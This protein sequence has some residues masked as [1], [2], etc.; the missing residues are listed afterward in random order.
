M[1]RFCCTPTGQLNVIFE[2][3]G[4]AE[5]AL[6]LVPLMS[7]SSVYAMTGIPRGDIEIQ[8]DGALLVRRIV[9]YNQVLFG[10]VNSN[11][12]HFEMALKDIEPINRQFDHFME[13]LITRRIKLADYQQ[14]FSTTDPGQ[15]KTVVE[16]EPWSS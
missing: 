3:S 8:L 6:R 16:I 9:R 12:R 4:A 15:I 14:A 5:T 11:R 13:R 7:R 1:V 2:A 10:S